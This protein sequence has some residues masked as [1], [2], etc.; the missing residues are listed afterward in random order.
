MGQT[1]PPVRG[2]VGLFGPGERGDPAGGA[3]IAEDGLDDPVTSAGANYLP[4]DRGMLKAPGLWGASVG[5]CPSFVTPDPPAAAQ[6]R[7]DLRDPLVPPGVHPPKE[8]RQRSVAEGHAINLRQ[9]G[10]QR[11]SS[12]AWVD[13]REVASPSIEAPQGVP[14]A[15]PTGIGASEV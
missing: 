6:A 5:P 12:R 3:M 10:H 1:E 11:S 13:R 15:I 2:R 8:V 9:E 14:G 4:T 7:Q